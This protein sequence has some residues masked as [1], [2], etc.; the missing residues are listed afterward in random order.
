MLNTE[1]QI[2]YYLLAIICIILIIKLI[3][4]TVDYI[5]KPF[6]KHSFYNVFYSHKKQATSENTHASFSNAF[7]NQPS[8][9]YSKKNSC[10][11]S[12][13]SRMLFYI[14]QALDDLHPTDCSSFYIFPQVSLHAFINIRDDLTAGQK[15][16]A[17]KYLLPKNVDFLICQCSKHNIR[18]NNNQTFSYYK[19]TPVLVI[20]IDGSSHFS[21]KRYG[22]KAFHYQQL[23]DNF[24]NNLFHDL[25]I[26]LLRYKLTNDTVRREDFKQL[27]YQLQKVLSEQ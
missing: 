24:K 5:I 7:I 1:I 13:E 19:Y 6:L 3:I 26:P 9:F 18:Q 16:A 25:N 8:I 10:M 21:P 17:Q 2:K 20:E 27:K 22:N 14:S 11:N 23:S 4:Y 12:N 15:T